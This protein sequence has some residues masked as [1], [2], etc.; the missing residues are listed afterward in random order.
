M[1]LRLTTLT[2]PLPV[3]LIKLLVVSLLTDTRPCMLS[4]SEVKLK[5]M[6][7]SSLDHS[8]NCKYYYHCCGSVFIIHH[9]VTI[10]TGLL[11]VKSKVFIIGVVMQEHVEENGN[12]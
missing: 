3:M 8:K 9:V 11:C 5:Q 7:N 12:S 2:I 10:F 6:P 4:S 1:L